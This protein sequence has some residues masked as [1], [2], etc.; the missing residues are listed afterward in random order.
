MLLKVWSIFVLLGFINQSAVDFPA[1]HKAWEN[2]VL[3][4][5]VSVGNIVIVNGRGCL[6][7]WE[8]ARLNQRP[9]PRAH[10]RTVSTISFFGS[11]RPHSYAGHVAISVDSSPK[12]HPSIPRSQR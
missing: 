2:G 3:H 5:D 1:H 12:R 10:E 11:V 6:I 7:D 9:D 4:R 8:L